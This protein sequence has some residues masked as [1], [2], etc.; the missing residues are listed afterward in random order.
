VRS[1][2]RRCPE[3][4]TAAEPHRLP[5]AHP[6][7]VEVAEP[8]RDAQA[9]RAA[10]R[11]PRKPAARP[12]GAGQSC[13]WRTAERDMRGE[14]MPII[15]LTLARSLQAGSMPAAERPLWRSAWTAGSRCHRPRRARRPEQKHCRS[16]HCERHRPREHAGECRRAAA[17]M[18]GTGAAAAGSRGTQDWGRGG[19][20]R[21]AHRRGCALSRSSARARSPP[22]QYSVTIIIC[23]APAPPRSAPPRHLSAPRRL[24]PDAISALT[25][26]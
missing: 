23:A 5:G 4:H 20:P 11:A 7:V 19:Q 26:S 10:P 3:H 18:R 1:I 8:A 12:A 9:D 25:T 22:A 6:F 24:S 17:G 2:E 14:G 15:G 21:G 16:P 13:G